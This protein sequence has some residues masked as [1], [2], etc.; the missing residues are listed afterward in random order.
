MAAVLAWIPP[1]GDLG[2]RSNPDP[3]RGCGS[4]RRGRASA[5]PWAACGSAGTDVG[6]SLVIVRCGKG[7]ALADIRGPAKATCW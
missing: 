4:T 6:L 7:L 3:E 1:G 5:V 2:E